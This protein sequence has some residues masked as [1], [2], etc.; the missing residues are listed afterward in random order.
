MT[1]NINSLVSCSCTPSQPLH[2]DIPEQDPGS[3]RTAV[4]VPTVRNFVLTNGS[5]EA[6][7]HQHN[8]QIACFQVRTCVAVLTLP[9]SLHCCIYA[10]A[11]LRCLAS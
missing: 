7:L 3:G 11:A 1:W 4:Q 6:W 2:D 5:F 8:L 10:S 9:A